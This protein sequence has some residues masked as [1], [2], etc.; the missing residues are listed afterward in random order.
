M[1]KNENIDAFW[2]IEDLI[3][4]R[5]K[6]ATFE[7]EFSDVTATEIVLDAQTSSGDVK[8]PPREIGGKRISPKALREYD[9]SALISHVKIFAWPTVFEFYKKFCHSNLCRS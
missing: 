2:D 4:E 9:G 5:P 1:P 6:K 7:R 3:P 8:I